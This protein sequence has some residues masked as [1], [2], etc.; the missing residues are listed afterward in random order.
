MQQAAAI[1]ECMDAWMD[2]QKG[3]SDD[4][5]SSEFVYNYAVM[6]KLCNWG[7]GDF[8]AFTSF[9]GWRGSS[10]GQEQSMTLEVMK[11]FQNP[12]WIHLT[13]TSLF[14][15]SCW[16]RSVWT[17]F[18]QEYIDSSVWLILGKKKK[19]FFHCLVFFTRPQCSP[20]SSLC[21]F[22]LSL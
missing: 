2:L 18:I 11:H 14:F 20:S 10:V 19:C 17:F 9:E 15:L 12:P 4:V 22:S 6:W 8:Q 3:K 21:L 16:K 1:A 13:E 7:S 5:G